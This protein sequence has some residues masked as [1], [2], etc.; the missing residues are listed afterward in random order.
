MLDQLEPS[1]RVIAGAEELAGGLRPVPEADAVG[2]PPARPKER[3]QLVDLWGDP[4]GRFNRVRN[5][6]THALLSGVS[7]VSK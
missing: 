5:L 3:D 2:A 7:S 1:L 4:G 6:S